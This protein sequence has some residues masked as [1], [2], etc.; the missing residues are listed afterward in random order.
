MR[1]HKTFTKHYK[2]VKTIKEMYQTETDVKKVGNTKRSLLK[3]TLRSKHTQLFC[4]E[5]GSQL[6]LKFGV[7]LTQATHLRYFACNASLVYPRKYECSFRK[8]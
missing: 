3:K 8:R 5:T 6:K 4:A 2:S 1:F 7:F